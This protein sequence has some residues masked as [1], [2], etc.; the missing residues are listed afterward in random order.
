MEKDLILEKNDVIAEILY[1][2][3]TSVVSKSNIPRY[4]DLIID[5]DQT[6][7]QTGHSV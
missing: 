3:F 1:D 4:Q 7:D 6:D 2:F 5:S